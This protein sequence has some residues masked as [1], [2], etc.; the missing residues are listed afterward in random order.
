MISQFLCQKNLP[1]LSESDQSSHIL[2][3]SRN[4]SPSCRI[5]GFVSGTRWLV[6]LQN[7]SH[8]PRM[9]IGPSSHKTCVFTFFA[10]QDT[11]LGFFS[12]FCFFD[13]TALT[14]T[15]RFHKSPARKCANTRTAKTQNGS[16]LQN[17]LPFSALKLKLNPDLKTKLWIKKE[18]WSTKRD[19]IIS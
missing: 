10:T 5:S 19:R 9:P 6:F 17:V 13:E 1:A 4:L 14:P 8:W 15:A 18:T 7:S 2:Q 11:L 16:A 12:H 3:F